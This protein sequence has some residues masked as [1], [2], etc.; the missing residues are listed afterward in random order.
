MLQVLGLNLIVAILYFLAG[1]LGQSA[2]IEPGNFTVF[3]PPV[4]IALAFVLKYK[5]KPLLGIVAGAFLVNLDGPIEGNGLGEIVFTAGLAVLAAVAALWGS[6]LLRRAHIDK[7]PFTNRSTI[8]RFILIAPVASLLVPSI[9][10]VMVVLT[11]S[12]SMTGLQTWLIWWLG[13]TLGLIVFT[14]ITFK[15][16]QASIATERVRLIYMTLTMATI[17]FL[18]AAVGITLSYA[19]YIQSTQERMAEL[20]EVQVLIGTAVAAFDAEYSA[21]AVP[22]GARSATIQ[23]L[24]QAINDVRPS[25]ETGEYLL[26]QESQGL[27]QFLASRRRNLST[28]PDDLA[29]GSDSDIP[30]LRALQGQTGTLIGND[31]RGARVLAAYSYLPALNVGIVVYEDIQTVRAP[32]IRTAV[33]TILISLGLIVIGLYIFKNL[34][35]YLIVAIQ[36]KA[37]DLEKLVA[38][39][40]E[41]IQH[42]E[43]RFRALIESAPDAM[44]VINEAGIIQM[45]N[46]QLSFL[47]GYSTEELLEKSVDLLVPKSVRHNHA[48][49]R[50][51][52]MKD[53]EVRFLDRNRNLKCLR[54]DGSAFSVDI[55][56]SPIVQDEEETLI[57]ASIRDT[58]EREIADTAIKRNLSDLADA[59]SAALNMMRDAE[60]SREKI[61]ESQ[62]LLDTSLRG[63]NLGLWDFD[64]K[65]G[66]LHIDD[67]YEKQLGYSEGKLQEVYGYD[68]GAAETLVHPED[69]PIVKKAMEDVIAGKT[70]EYRAEYRSKT[71]DGNWKWL[72]GA[73]QA[74]TENAGGKGLRIV[75]IQ[76]DI[77]TQKRLEE[78][79]L[80]EKNRLDLA[81]KGGN[82]GFWEFSNDDSRL[83]VSNVYEELLGYPENPFDQ[84][85]H[86]T[87]NAWIEMMHPEDVASYGEDLYL[88]S[89]GREGEH[90]S[91]YRTE[92]RIKAADGTWRW[93]M[94]A[95]SQVFDS[96]GKFTGKVSGIIIDIN[97]LKLLEA[98]LRVSKEEAESAAEAKASFLA[99]M[100]HEIRT[101]MNAV[102]GMVELLRQTNMDSDQMHMLQT[103]SSSG[104]SLLTIINDILDFSKIEAGRL[105]LEEISMPLCNV[106]EDAVR[107]VAVNIR[108]KNLRLVTYVDPSISQFVQGD[109]VRFRQII[110]NLVGNAIKFTDEGTI[111]ISAELI[112]RKGGQIVVQLSIRDEGIGISEEAQKQLFTAFSQ[113]ESS[114]TR[115]YGGTGLGLS[116]CERLTTLMGG[117]IRVES[118][119]GEGSTF[120][121]E[122]PFTETEKV[123]EEK[124]EN[125]AGVRVLL[126]DENHYERCALRKYLEHWQA[127]V[128][129]LGASEGSV[130]YCLNAK[131]M[132]KQV[133]IMVI[134]PAPDAKKILALKQATRDAGLSEINILAINPGGR[135]EAR[136]HKDEYVQLDTDPVSRTAFISAIAICMGRASPE[137]HYEEDIHTFNKVAV[138]LSVEDAEAAG[139][140]ILVAEDNHTNRDV[141]GRQLKLLG[142]TCEMAEDGA[143]G[144]EMW[145]SGRYALLL[146]DCHM[147]NLDGFQLT[148]GIRE[149]EKNDGG[150]ERAPILAITANALQGEAERCLA[151]GMDGY[152]SKPVDLKDLA[153]NIDQWMPTEAKGNNKNVLAQ[154]VEDHDIMVEKPTEPLLEN[155]TET[156]VVDTNVLKSLLG[157]DEEMLRD[158]I[159]DFVAPSLD[160]VKELQGGHTRR[161]AKEV[162][163]AAHKLKSSSG[164]IGAN[165]L[166]DL[167]YTLEKAGKDNDF[168]TIDARIGDLETLMAEVTDF[169]ER[170]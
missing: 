155:A 58:T 119:L 167:C 65:S 62:Q 85:V 86:T 6:F 1:K 3:W 32:F 91:E 13:S 48:T 90:R 139:R 141:I 136:L 41:E 2:A 54:K 16:M 87:L 127:E 4:G 131:A 158:V 38:Q 33:I 68:I 8:V 50:K 23:Q 69:L 92:C 134:G 140:L 168:D 109:Q 93:L 126:L 121:A 161:D 12:S 22:G 145:K 125:L 7:D 110:I 160:I 45:A 130:D 156:P 147:P 57:A 39:K 99:S 95:G 76:Q 153:K 80:K 81:L 117:S 106:L 11:G 102:I 108:N 67:L 61:A 10:T 149:L 146:T 118:V 72:M 34:S 104:Q 21:D 5:L 25:S 59:R 15:L 103:I 166:A 9:G 157:D 154:A 74:L 79:V 40:T 159:K 165:A 75:G 135:A 107:T 89:G 170:F 105:D 18:I 137:I 114:T 53:P 115:K 123:L 88:F 71:S 46:R 169:I 84:G 164:S 82:L 60:D 129:E 35:S 55:A 63:A 98:D 148:A 24:A 19:T 162:Q 152:M 112:Q 36:R 26:A 151:A 113:A 163:M 138:A 28:L 29:I 83:I 17:S 14:P 56:L 52:Y 122:I 94:T 97:D 124:T 73:G 142:H 144:L 96:K 77:D 128:E 132:G 143:E 37:E 47:T 64:V 101:P 31:W 51:N 100:S 133:D 42:N 150:T 27:V 78:E 20:V 66:K 43:E 111:G 30:M 116:I 70:A 49:H 120:I 44:I